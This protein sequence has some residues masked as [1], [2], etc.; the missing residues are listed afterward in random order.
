MGIEAIS[1]RE[2]LFLWALILPALVFLWRRWRKEQS[3]QSYA[4]RHLWPWVKGD[5]SI[6]L[7]AEQSLWKRWIYRFFSWFQPLNL[8]ALAWILLIIALAEPRQQVAQNLPPERQGLDLL[9]VLDLSPSMAATDVYP[10]RFLMAKNLLQSLNSRLQPMDRIGIM[11]FSGQ[12]HLISPLSYDHRL[13]DHYLN[14][15]QPD[16]LPTRGS[17]V[18]FGYVAAYQHLKQTARQAPAILMITDGRS[19]SSPIPP[20]PDDLAEL[21]KL[22]QQFFEQN[23]SPMTTD[24]P[25]YSITVGVGG[26]APVT[27]KDPEDPSGQLQYEGNPALVQLDEGFIRDFCDKVSADYFEADLS[28]DFVEKL[29][30]RLSSRA[31]PVE[32]ILTM[33]TWHTYSYPFMVLGLM[34]L[35]LAFY[36]LAIIKS[37]R[38]QRG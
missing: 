14:L 12:A 31:E 2:P 22:Y 30:H 6:H 29:L 37:G 27:L 19:K 13:F 23:I 7:G 5:L 17:A 9:V 28:Q 35:I 10:N 32:S 8:L 3:Q 11:V 21:Q 34:C 26:Q 38:E 25:L 36:P 16:L 4:D 15:L 33:Q 18:E 1:W 20:I 24:F